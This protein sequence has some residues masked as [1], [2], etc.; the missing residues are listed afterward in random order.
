MSHNKL[1]YYSHLSIM[2]TDAA[3]VFVQKSHTFLK[4]ELTVSHVQSSPRKGDSAV[5]HSTKPELPSHVK[6]LHDK[7][8]EMLGLITSE[9]TTTPVDSGQITTNIIPHDVVPVENSSTIKDDVEYEKNKLIVT[10]IPMKTTNIFLTFYLE[11]T[12]EMEK[13]DYSFELKENSAL[14]TFTR[15][16]TIEGIGNPICILTSYCYIYTF[17]VGVLL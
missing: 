14:L 8:A 10:N 6:P 11:R 16:Y 13:K 7:S 9:E 4:N 12:L 1:K 5:T 2:S 3:C 15:Q 17:R